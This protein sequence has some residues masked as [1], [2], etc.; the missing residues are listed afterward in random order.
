[1]KWLWF[2]ILETGNTAVL[3]LDAQSGMKRTCMTLV[4]LYSNTSPLD[5]VQLEFLDF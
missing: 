3:E 2:P 4:K 5:K 1:L